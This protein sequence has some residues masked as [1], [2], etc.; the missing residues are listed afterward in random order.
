MAVQRFFGLRKP[1]TLNG[2]VIAH[3]VSRG[4]LFA[5]MFILG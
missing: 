1:K 5:V 3:L 4:N 2:E